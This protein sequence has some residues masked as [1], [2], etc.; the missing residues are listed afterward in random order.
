MA[1]SQA[2]HGRWPTWLAPLTAI[3]LPVATVRR[4][5]EMRLWQAAAVHAL[6]VVMAL[7]ALTAVLAWA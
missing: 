2:K 6:G 3:V 5:E 4:T 7:E 1:G